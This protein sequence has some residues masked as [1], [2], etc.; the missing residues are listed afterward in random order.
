[1]VTKRWTSLH[2][3]YVNK[4][5]KCVGTSDPDEYCKAVTPSGKVSIHRTPQDDEDA[6][7]SASREAEEDH[8]G[9][10]RADPGEDPAEA[11][12]AEEEAELEQEEEGEP[13]EEEAF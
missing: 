4:S 7:V 11:A 10:G 13:Q 1:M 12:A 2:L 9:D 6:Q 3:K 8:R 5:N